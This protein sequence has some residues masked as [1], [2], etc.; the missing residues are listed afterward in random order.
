MFSVHGA[1]PDVAT[2]ADE[3]HHRPAIFP[4]HQPLQQEA[5]V[6]GGEPTG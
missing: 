3:D 6:H 2:E 4:G 5:A 1:E